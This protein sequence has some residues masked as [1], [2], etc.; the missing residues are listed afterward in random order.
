[1]THRTAI[2]ELPPE[3]I[4]QIKAGE[5]VERPAAVV[6]ELLENALDAGAMAVEIDIDAGGLKWI[7]VRDDGQGI[8]VEQ[9]PLALARHATS[10]IASLDDLLGVTSLGFRGEAL[11]SIAS[12]SRMR[13]ASRASGADAAAEIVGDGQGEFIGPKPVAHPPGTTVEVHDLFYNTPARRKFLRAERTEFQHLEQA[14]RRIALSRFDVGIQLTHN[15]RVQYRLA[16]ANER[17]AQEK[18]LA[19][20]CGAA[21][22]EQALHIDH[23]AAGMRLSGW[24]SRPAFSRSQAD[25]QYVF[26]NGRWVRDKT[27]THALRQA[28]N[29]V[30]FHGRQPAYVLALQMPPEQVDVNVHP[31]KTE[32]RFRAGQQVHEFLRR[33]V[34]AALAET[35]PGSIDPT[36]VGFDASNSNALRLS[37][38]ATQSSLPG[39]LPARTDSLRSDGVAWSNHGVGVAERAA[40]TYATPTANAATTAP[41]SGPPL[42]YALA[43]LSGVYVLAE[44]AQGL[45]LVDMHAAHERIVYE[46]LKQG[47]D[48][49]GVTS[50]P[51]LVPVPMAVSRGEADAAERFAESL[52]DLGL[53]LDRSAPEAVVIRAVPALLRD[54]D[55]EALARDL[56]SDLVE[57]DSPDRI[58]TQIDDVLSTMACHGSVRAN[59]KLTLDEMNAL[60][61]DMEATERSGQCNH[62]RP[63]WVQLE[64]KEL[65]RLFLRGQ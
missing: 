46:R 65:D 56:L 23:E 27:I 1:M 58:R 8:P 13:L 4:N 15:G 48:V 30:L 11:P 26:L 28:Y 2:H 39:G 5:V 10:K 42:G 7:R 43:Q 33:S 21:F 38:T 40:P 9:L 49:G 61:R 36:R 37:P 53:Q 24:L 17:G 31:A 57:H 32:V 16:P 47:V 6:K 64:L 44:N 62:G 45:V 55:A 59:R 14:V 20:L 41:A 25:M 22:A 52:H 18:R 54:A 3:L 63:T 19:E 29:D 12:V 60:L 35:R 50:Q 34:Q 51:L